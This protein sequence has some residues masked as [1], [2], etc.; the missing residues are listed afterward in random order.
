MQTSLRKIAR[1]SV[2]IPRMEN[3]Q[4]KPEAS[5][6]EY[7][8]TELNRKNVHQNHERR[9]SSPSTLSEAEMCSIVEAAGGKYVGVVNQIPGMVESVVL[10]TSRRTRSTLALPST[11]LTVAAVRQQLADSDAAFNQARPK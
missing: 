4:A 1:T 3:Y 7:T 9:S 8:V 11:R 10:F 2:D 6:R 5:A